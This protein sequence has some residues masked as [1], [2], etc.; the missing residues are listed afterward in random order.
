MRPVPAQVRP[1]DKGDQLSGSITVSPAGGSNAAGKAGV[2][3]IEVQGWASGADAS[4][5]ALPCSAGPTEKPNG[6][7]PQSDR[8]PGACQGISA[9]RKRQTRKPEKMSTMMT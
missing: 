9:L 4:T 6:G 8:L 7:E 3:V 2:Q 5:P 1:R